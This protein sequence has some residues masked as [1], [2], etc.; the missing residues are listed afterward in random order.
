MTLPM[1]ALFIV[2]LFAFAALAVD[3]G[4]LYTA[5]TSAQHAADAAALA[6]AFTFSTNP[7]GAQPD[8]AHEAALTE[9]QRYK[10]L[11]KSIDRASFATL[12]APCPTSTDTNWVCVNSSLRRVTVNVALR[13]QNAV[14][15]Y[16]ARVIGWNAVNVAALAAAEAAPHASG[17]RC[18]RPLF[19]PMSADWTKTS[20]DS[21]SSI[22]DTNGQLKASMVGAPVILWLQ[23]SKTP[24]LSAQLPGNDGLLGQKLQ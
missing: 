20:C 19:I 18:L 5:R 2:V 7:T 3:V 17:T 24:L 13:G 4:V 14:S 15:V 9:A 23:H 10:V 22:F 21:S 11:G 16:F 8:L 1:T 12:T 6:G